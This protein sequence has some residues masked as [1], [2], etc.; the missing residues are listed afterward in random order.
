MICTLGSLA[1][2][3]TATI[4]L[5]VVPTVRKDVVSDTASATVDASTTDP[6]AANN[7]ATASAQIK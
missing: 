3:A 2:G 4:T 5:T 7:T 6:V 1:S